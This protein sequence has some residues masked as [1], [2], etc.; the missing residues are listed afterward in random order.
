MYINVV[1]K[2]K[3]MHVM[4]SRTLI[5]NPDKE[6]KQKRAY[7]AVFEA[8]DVLCK[9]LVVGQPIKQAY[10]AVSELFATKYSDLREQLHSNFG[11]GIGFGIKEDKLVINESNETLVQPHMCFHARITLNKV[12]E[13]PSKSIIALGET[14]MID[15]QGQ[16]V[17]LTQGIYRKF[18]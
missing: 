12:H 5:V 4:A 3:D 14:I 18:G 8:I 7:G 10:Q 16:A 13:K 17:I 9:N 11:F 2:Y 6:G 1:G 15:A